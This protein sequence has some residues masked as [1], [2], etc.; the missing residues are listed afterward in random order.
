MRRE[1]QQG[2]LSRLGRYECDCCKAG[3]DVYD[4]PVCEAQDVIE[5][6]DAEIE[7]LREQNEAL[8][9]LYEQRRDLLRSCDTEVRRL[10]ADLAA[11]TPQED[12][13]G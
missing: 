6:Q 2:L 5:A 10:R 3:R 7:R 4:C 13:R 9:A 12:D 8:Q 1:R 11:A